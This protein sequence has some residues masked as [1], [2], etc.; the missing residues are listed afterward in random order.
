[1]NHV[2]EL[3]LR[4]ALLAFAFFLDEASLF[5]HIARAEQQHAFAGQAIAPGPTRFLIIT[6]DV[7]RQ[8]VMND[9]LDFGFVDSHPKLNR[10]EKH[11]RSILPATTIMSV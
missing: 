8:N 1:M 7:L 11:L 10:L 9:K 3:F 2:A 5:H 6:F 4:D